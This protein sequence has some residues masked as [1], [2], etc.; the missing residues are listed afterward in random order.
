LDEKMLTDLLS[1]NI[2]IL[3]I[4][5]AILQ[6]GFGSAV[7]EYAQTQGYYHSHIDRIG[8]PDQFI[9]HGDVDSLLEEIG[10]TTE[11]VIKRVSILARKKQQR[12]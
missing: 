10:L 3:T 9:E 1:K 11:E 2:P 4:E 8:I 12:A 6:G 7:L 5:E